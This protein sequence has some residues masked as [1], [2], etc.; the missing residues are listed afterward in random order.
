MNEP[1]VRERF[2]Q[3]LQR[4]GY[5]PD[6][7]QRAAVERLEQLRQ[8]LSG[9][10]RS[11]LGH[12]LAGERD[13]PAVRGVYLWGAVGRGKTWLMD[14]FFAS[15]PAV[16]RRR[17]HFHHFM[18]DVHAELA[19]LRGQSE[20][21][22]VVARKLA[23]HAQLLCLD[24]LFV[25]DIADAMLL[26][27]LFE[28]LLHQGVTL[29]I[30]SNVPPAGLYRDGLQRARFLPAI[31]L[32]E[33]ELDVLQVD[34]GTDYRLRQLRQAPVYLSLADPAAA[35]RAMSA[36]FE[37]LADAHGNTDR[38]LQI[39]GRMLRA[40]RRRGDVV[41][42]RFRTLC[43]GARSTA[44][45]VQIAHQFH[46][47]LLSSVPQLGAGQD[48]AARRFIALVDEF[49][50]RGVKLIVSAACDPQALYQGSRLAPEF[51]RTASRLVE[52]QSESYLAQPH[53]P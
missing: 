20:P 15:V 37:R 2:E 16:S 23:R 9:R 4:R 47:V 27:T 50:D 31:A 12:W 49:Y 30:T 24:E 5:V 36:W 32:L 7:A 52:M 19:A 22:G 53:L 10:R 21:L 14:L 26:G 28:A 25:E 18:R 42:F 45:Y 48:D 46:A 41:W 1:G 40:V 43:D 44:D 17:Q 8:A 29:V 33:S 51:K 34:G 38:R 13:A 6:A 11:W 3:E 35:R 39:S